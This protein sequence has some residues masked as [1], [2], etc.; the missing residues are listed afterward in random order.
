MNVVVVVVVLVISG[1]ISWPHCMAKIA[2][3]SKLICCQLTQIHVKSMREK[4]IK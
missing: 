3:F 1:L 2:T 4:S